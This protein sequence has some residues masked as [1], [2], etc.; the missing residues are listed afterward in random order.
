MVMM[1]VPVFY[2][3][4]AGG[5]FGAGVMYLINKGERQKNLRMLEIYWNG[6]IKRINEKLEVLSKDCADRNRAI[7]H[8]LST[9]AVDKL[10]GNSW[11]LKPGKGGK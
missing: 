5:M 4:F 7:F 10:V 2:A 6:D 9:K 8:D 1:L 11:S 3:G